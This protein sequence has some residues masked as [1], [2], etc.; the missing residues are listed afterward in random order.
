[1]SIQGEGGGGGGGGG[2]GEGGG[3]E[4]AEKEGYASKDEEKR[5]GVCHSGAI[6]YVGELGELQDLTR[7]ARGKEVK[8]GSMGMGQK[9][10]SLVEQKVGGSKCARRQV[11]WE[12]W[13][14]GRKKDRERCTEKQSG[15]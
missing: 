2:G 11:R 10:E 9:S 5:E 6:V 7:N 1:M 8:G 15:N 14:T 13:V 12:H 3:N 4:C